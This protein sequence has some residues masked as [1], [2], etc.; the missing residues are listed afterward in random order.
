MTRIV[1]IAVLAGLSTLA[2]VPLWAQQPQQS[3]IQGTQPT[4][5]GVG[6]G[7]RLNTMRP[8]PPSVIPADP[9]QRPLS[10][11]A[12]PSTGPSVPPRFEIEAKPVEPTVRNAPKP[13]LDEQ[14]RLVP[15][16]VRIAPTRAYDPATGRYF[17]TIPTPAPR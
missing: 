13:V 2:L 5:Q 12:I 15:G 9:S 14:G 16:A 10:T 17:Q 8:A 11:G 4:P 6:V 1:F 7:P 3:P